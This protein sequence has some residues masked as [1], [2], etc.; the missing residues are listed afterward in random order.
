MS[1][2][3]LTNLLAE[4]KRKT[5][6]FES[7]EKEKQAMLFEK[8]M[9]KIIKKLNRRLKNYNGQGDICLNLAEINLFIKWLFSMNLSIWD[10]YHCQDHIVEEELRKM[11]YNVIRL[12]G[13]YD[14][15]HHCPI[16]WIKLII[17]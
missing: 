1:N 5:K 12:C 16:Y 7:E 15:T 13:C 11:G 6:I 9:N 4:A 14:D 17:D 10:Y 3:D 8:L 2:Y